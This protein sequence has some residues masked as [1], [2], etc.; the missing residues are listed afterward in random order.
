[1]ECRLRFVADG[2]ERAIAAYAPII[3][4]QVAAELSA[5]VTGVGIW[6]RLW[7]SWRIERELRR[8]LKKLFS[9]LSLY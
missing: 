4:E 3:R 5:R 7:L 6:R 2:H 8:R 9:P 1:M